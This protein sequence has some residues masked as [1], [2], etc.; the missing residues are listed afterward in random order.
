[1]TFRDIYTDVLRERGM[2]KRD[3]RIHLIT[4]IPEFLSELK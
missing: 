4:P 3:I 1:M 2:N